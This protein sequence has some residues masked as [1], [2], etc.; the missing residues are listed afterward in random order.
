MCVPVE[1]TAM[2]TRIAGSVHRWCH[3][4]AQ[5][6][7]VSPSGLALLDQEPQTKVTCN[8]CAEGLLAT[9]ADAKFARPP[10]SYEELRDAGWTNEQQREVGR[11]L[12]RQYKR[13]SGR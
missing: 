4:C 7:W 2:H 6:V 1:G 12:V 9:E 13:R 11:A 10:G 8:P 5:A 3:V